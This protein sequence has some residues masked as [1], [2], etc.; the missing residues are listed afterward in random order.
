MGD[1]VWFALYLLCSSLMLIVNKLVSCP[2]PL[3]PRRESQLN[4]ANI[5]A[6]LGCAGCEELPEER[7]VDRANCHHSRDGRV[8]AEDTVLTF[9]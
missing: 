6:R 3:P 1:G 8:H 4:R 2:Q 5:I 9:G 7:S